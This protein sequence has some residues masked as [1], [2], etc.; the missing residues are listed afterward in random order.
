MTKQPGT[1]LAADWGKPLDK[2]AVYKADVAGRAIERIDSE[3]WNL[4]LLLETARE[5]VEAGK[6]PV[7]VS[8]DLALGIPT[9]YFQSAK[10]GFARRFFAQM[11]SVGR[12]PCDPTTSQASPSFR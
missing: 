7:V 3:E 8:L 11:A 1:L 12:P 5:I 9:Q 2:R 4:Q 6:G 10:R